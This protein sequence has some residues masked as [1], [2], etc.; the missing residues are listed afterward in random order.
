MVCMW[1]VSGSIGVIMLVL[2]G[3]VGLPFDRSA[4]HVGASAKGAVVLRGGSLQPEPETHSRSRSSGRNRMGFDRIQRGERWP[5][6]RC[7]CGDSWVW[8]EGDLRTGVTIPTTSPERGAK[9]ATDRSSW[10]CARSKAAAA[11]SHHAPCI[12]RALFSSFSGPPG[13]CYAAKQ[14]VGSHSAQ[15][16][17]RVG[18]NAPS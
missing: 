9:P 10:N 14:R 17:P 12:T 2:V 7:C 13:P 4:K 1:S 5:S 18:P 8:G 3:L 15:P 6:A 11:R 16:R